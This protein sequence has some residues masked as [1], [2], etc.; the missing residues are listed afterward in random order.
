[1]DAPPRHPAPPADAA[2]ATAPAS[3]EGGDSRLRWLWAALALV[4]IAEWT[5]AVATFLGH[6]RLRWF[7]Q[8]FP[9]LYA[10]ARLVA[11]GAGA[12]VYDTRTIAAAELAA[13]GRPVGG[14]GVLAYFNPPFFALLLSPLSELSLTDAYRAWT[15]LSVGLVVVD[16]WLI[17]L[18]ADGMRRSS[19][20]AVVLA[21]LTLFPLT[22]GLQ[23][24]QF[25]LILVTSWAA[26][27]VLLRRGRTRSAGI[28]LA[29]LLIKPELLLP[30]A[31]YLFWKRQWGVFATLAPITGIALAVSLW[32][33]GPGNALTYPAYL[34][35]STTWSA[36][37]TATNVMFG[38]NGIV[39]MLW[40]PAQVR[41]ALLIAAALSA[42]TLV[43]LTRA[44]RGRLDLRSDRFIVQ[45]ALLTV[46]TLLVDPHLY[47]QDTIILAPAAAALLALTPEAARGRVAVAMLAGWALLGFGVFPNEHLGVNAFGLYLAAA[48]L[49]LALRPRLFLAPRPERIPRAEA[50]LAAA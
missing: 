22:Y 11:D 19:R 48:A 24:G 1:M 3:A 47:L 31:A 5:Q 10:A 29:P 6:D 28:A 15:V 20:A 14:S 9:A 36:N 46:A 33:I 40:D 37:G 26:A 45:W 16:A 41:F 27:F 13:A 2:V 49:A 8:D 43:G 39:A 34:L 4:G 32:V 35:D 7:S 44:W 12:G 50:H 42:A 18:I 38:W 17:W 30:I 25:S 21:F 23:V